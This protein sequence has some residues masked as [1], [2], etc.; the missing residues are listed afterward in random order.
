M[1]SPSASQRIDR[2]MDRASAALVETRYWEAE[3]QAFQALELARRE[4]DWER[5]ARITMPLLEARRQKRLAAVDAPGRWVVERA[6]DVPQPI[7][8]GLYLLQPPMT[9]MDARMLREAA[10]DTETPVITLAREPLTRS[11]QWPVAAVGRLIFRARTAP[12]EGVERDGSRMTRD[13]YVGPDGSEDFTAFA[14]RDDFDPWF[15]AAAEALGDEG[16]RQ[17][18][19]FTG[20]EAVDA[21]LDRIDAVPD[22]EKLHQ[23]LEAA[24]RAA[25]AD[26]AEAPDR[27]PDAN[28]RLAELQ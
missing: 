14:Q 2:L 18:A 7:R 22:H 1:P 10:A 8:P 3:R 26:H 23:A 19:H 5:M 17:C 11:G 16:A 21:L 6:E 27:L 20:S 9:G 25:A 12:P 15:L 13:R 4:G 28:A 24:C